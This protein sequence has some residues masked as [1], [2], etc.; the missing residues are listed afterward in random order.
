MSWQSTSLAHEQNPTSTFLGQ[1][2]RGFQLDK[3]RFALEKKLSRYVQNSKVTD[4]QIKPN[5][6]EKDYRALY[7]EAVAGRKQAE[8]T[9]NQL[10]KQLSDYQK[11]ELK[12]DAMSSEVAEIREMLEIER[13]T[14]KT[15]LYR[16]YIQSQVHSL[17]AQLEQHSFHQSDLRK[18]LLEANEQRIDLIKEAETL[19]RTL[20]DLKQLHTERTESIK[21]QINSAETRRKELEVQLESLL[22]EDLS[23]DPALLTKKT[24]LSEQFAALE[25]QYEGQVSLQKDLEKS[26]REAKQRKRMES[27]EQ[28]VANTTLQIEE[29]SIKLDKSMEKRKKRSK[30]RRHTQSPLS[31]GRC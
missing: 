24:T 5:R 21:T 2:T 3:R 4:R 13:N 26:L 16:S 1:N 28:R 19:S 11:L 15:A 27:W 8:S 20:L 23:V 10:Q 6:P 29:L 30:G 7:E 14:A 17:Q 22:A 31:R 12:A 18:A 9:Q 25:R